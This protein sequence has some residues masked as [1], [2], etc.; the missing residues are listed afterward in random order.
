[1]SIDNIANLL[2]GFGG[3]GNTVP[4]QLTRQD[5]TLPVQNQQY[6]ATVSYSGEVAFSQE[7]PGMNNDPRYAS[8]GGYNDIEPVSIEVD[9]LLELSGPTG[10]QMSVSPADPMYQI[11]VATAQQVFDPNWP[12]FQQA[13][14]EAISGHDPYQG[15]F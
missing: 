7:Q 3:G 11:L 14:M 6:M 15:Q 12:E 10:E 2:E 5:V 1:M 13:A 9:A 8:P 4:F